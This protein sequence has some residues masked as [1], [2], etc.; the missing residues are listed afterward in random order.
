M[1][2][3]SVDMVQ[4]PVCKKETPHVVEWRGPV[5]RRGEYLACGYCS[6]CNNRPGIWLSYLQKKMIKVRMS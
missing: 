6:I 2:D 1:D 5:S 4:C 3:Q